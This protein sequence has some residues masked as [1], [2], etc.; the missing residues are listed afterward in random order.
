MWKRI[1]S[2]LKY[3]FYTLLSDLYKKIF[4]DVAK[5][6]YK[7]QE[8]RDRLYIIGAGFTLVSHYPNANLIFFFVSVK[9]TLA[10]Y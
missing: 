3:Y 8:Y 4:F 9:L 6:I 5:D 1:F 7:R 2:L 10:S